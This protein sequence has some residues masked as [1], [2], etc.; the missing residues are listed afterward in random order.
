MSMPNPLLSVNPEQ[1]AQRGDRIYEPILSMARLNPLGVASP[2]RSYLS[3]L[4]KPT[5][6]SV[7][8]IRTADLPRPADVSRLRPVSQDFIGSRLTSRSRA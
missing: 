4:W 8:E 6:E 5:D 7:G 1:V 3:Q 2:L